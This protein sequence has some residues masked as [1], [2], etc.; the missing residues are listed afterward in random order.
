MYIIDGKN[1]LSN[2]ESLL[3]RGN[4]L[5]MFK[6]SLL[7]H[8]QTKVRLE[9]AETRKKL[10]L[11]IVKFTDEYDKFHDLHG[12]GSQWFINFSGKSNK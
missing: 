4:F 1:T 2:I 5:R 7:V 10:K 3:V 6:V 11:E 12:I 9:D 8:D